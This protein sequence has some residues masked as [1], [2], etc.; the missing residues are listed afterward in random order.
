MTVR[1]LDLVD[2]V[3]GELSFTQML[4]F[5]CGG[6]MPTIAETKILDACLVT[7]MEHGWTPS[8]LITRLMI[9][10]VPQE[11]QVAI[12]SGLLSL[13]SVFAGTSEGCA[14]ILK[15][16]IDAGGDLQAYCDHVVASYRALRKPIPGFGHPL[17]KPDDPRT[18]KLISTGRLYRVGGQYID[19]LLMLSNTVDAA[20]GKHVTINATGAIGALLLEIGL[21]PGVM[22][23]LAVVS[24][25]GGLIGHIVE[26][27]ET[28]AARHIWQLAEEN[29][30][31]EAPSKD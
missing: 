17:H 19:L 30:P 14:E 26:E 13:G 18:I 1:G 15:A 10:S 22:R 2:D 4:Y 28:H 3:I 29:I 20:A 5:L 27:R 9:D 23:G 25:S 7:L 24:R 31:Y 16:G 6:R 12:A 11:S 21:A 8:S